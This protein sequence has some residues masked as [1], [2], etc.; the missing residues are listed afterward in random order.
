[1]NGSYAVCHQASLALAYPQ[2]C[3]Q[4]MDLQRLSDVLQ[5][6]HP[7]PQ[8]DNVHVHRSIQTT[9]KN[10]DELPIHNVLALRLTRFPLETY[11]TL[12]KESYEGQAPHP[13]HGH[14]Q[15]QASHSI[16][17]PRLHH[18]Q[19]RLGCNLPCASKYQSLLGNDVPF[20]DFHVVLK[21]NLSFHPIYRYQQK[22]LHHR[23]N[24]SASQARPKQ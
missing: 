6:P 5:S 15:A 20:Q 13:I 22:M 7:I 16:H 2:L 4:T 18:V 9:L 19:T 24:Q 8:T 23:L 21:R 1:M 10:L 3:F 17:R 12:M 11:L 14:L